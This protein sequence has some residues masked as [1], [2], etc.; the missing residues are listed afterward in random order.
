ML[1][2]DTFDLL[3]GTRT[4]RIR[5]LG[6]D[7]PETANQET[8]AQC[9]AATAT[10][11]LQRLL[12]AGTAALVTIDPEADD[13]DRFG[14]TLGY[15][16]R[17]GFGRHGAADAGGR[18]GGCVGAEEFADAQPDACLPEGRV[19]GTAGQDKTLEDLPEPRALGTPGREFRDPRGRA[20][21]KRDRRAGVSA[22]P[23][24][25]ATLDD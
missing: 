25:T 7:A 24:A 22:P 14:R 5:M 18:H 9:G 11:A 19:E 8:K 16:S 3:D 13:H 17:K 4:H 10:K 1:D 23:Q 21:D 15:V 20:F 12:P 6:I 2:G